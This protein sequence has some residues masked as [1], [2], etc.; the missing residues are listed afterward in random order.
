MVVG[1]RT[2]LIQ[3]KPAAI[4]SPALCNGSTLPLIQ[5][6]IVL[7]FDTFPITQDGLAQKT[8]LS[9]AHKP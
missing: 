3:R 4:N 2:R 1:L 7:T 9:Y 5:H 8:S 6:A